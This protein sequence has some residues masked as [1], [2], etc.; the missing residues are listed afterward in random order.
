MSVVAVPTEQTQTRNG[1][2]VAFALASRK[3]LTLR[4]YEK[5]PHGGERGP[6][7]IKL[8]SCLAD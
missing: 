7:S 1:Q 2:V 3:E 8:R 6:G 4:N 5:R